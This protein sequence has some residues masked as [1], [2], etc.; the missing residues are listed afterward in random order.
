M[1]NI[2]YSYG[3]KPYLN[4]TNRCPCACVFCVRTTQDGVGNAGTLWHEADPTWQEIE[5]ALQ[6][7]DFTQESEAVFCGY[8]E[9]LCALEHL[10][11]TA[12]WLKANYPAMRLRLNTIGLGDLINGRPVAHELAGLIDTVSVSLN[13]PDA[14][15]FHQLVRS[16][17]GEAAFDA[18]LR[19]ARDCQAHVP[20]VKF[21]VVNVLT[22][23][24]LAQCRALAAEMGIALRVRVRA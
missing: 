6:Q 24:E 3:G 21:S 11:Q 5:Q 8:G 19:F 12:A 4:L 17:W 7:H 15:R 16:R 18:M 2:I 14:V 23:Q 22:E 1:A 9:P 20:N 10:K 13:A